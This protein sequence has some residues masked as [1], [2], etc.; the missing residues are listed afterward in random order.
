MNLHG[1]KEKNRHDVC[2][3]MGDDRSKVFG[4]ILY[5]YIHILGAEGS[6]Q[7]TPFGIPIGGKGC[8]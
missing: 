6:Y 5:I 8:P 7:E 4:T 3:Q 2:V 1:K